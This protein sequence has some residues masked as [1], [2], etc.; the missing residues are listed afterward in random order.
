MLQII[1]L[2]LVKILIYSANKSL[3]EK[4]KKYVE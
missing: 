1:A 4:D 3:Y 2:V